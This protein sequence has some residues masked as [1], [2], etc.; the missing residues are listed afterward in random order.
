M[1]TY[2]EHCADC[3][4]ILGKDWSVVHLWLDELFAR[5]G[6]TERHR[7][8]RHHEKGIEEVRAK[9]G[10]QAA[11]AARIHIERDFGGW[12]P[13]DEMDVQK[14]R[15]GVVQVPPGYDY[16]DGVLTKKSPPVV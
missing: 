6:F 14:W 4:R 10:D 9:W 16:K 8:V 3:Q 1:A 7:D 12:V 15:M 13:R 5:M 11:E 2:K